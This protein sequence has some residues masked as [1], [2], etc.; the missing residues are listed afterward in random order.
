MPLPFAAV[1]RETANGR[2]TKNGA[3]LRARPDNPARAGAHARAPLPERI[4]WTAGRA[5]SF[6]YC[7]GLLSP[8]LPV[9]PAIR[10]LSQA[11]YPGVVAFA[12]FI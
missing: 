4:K 8:C 12:P 3:R 2:K 11:A 1:G 10:A 9:T 7:L 5:G 6:A